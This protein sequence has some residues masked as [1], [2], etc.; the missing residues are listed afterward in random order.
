MTTR[1]Y[2][3]RELVPTRTVRCTMV[4]G[5]GTCGYG[6]TP[7]YGK[8]DALVEEPWPFSQLWPVSSKERRRRQQQSRS[9]CWSL[10]VLASQLM[11][12]KHGTRHHVQRARARHRAVVRHN[13]IEAWQRLFPQFEPDA[14]PPMPNM[15]TRILQP[16]DF[17]EISCWLSICSC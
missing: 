8:R 13:G 17:S 16:G 1:S 5:A 10:L 15:M 14:G 6:T 12:D 11:D 9:R 7:P 4:R 3:L 2:G